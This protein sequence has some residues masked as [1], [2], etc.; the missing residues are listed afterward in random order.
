[1][2]TVIIAAICWYFVS[3]KDNPNVRKK[4]RSGL[5]TMG[6][7]IAA[8][9][10]FFPISI[11]L[12]VMAAVVGGL[13]SSFGSLIPFIII[14]SIIK[15]IANGKKNATKRE[16]STEYQEIKKN[17]KAAAEYKLTRSTG[18]RVKIVSKFNKKYNLR[19][20]D[21]QIERIM[22]ASYV[23]YYWEKEIYDM[24][25]DYNVPAEWLKSSTDW[26]RAYL[27][28]FPVMDIASD[29]N[30]QRTIV[31]NSYLQIFKAVQGK[32]Y[33]SVDEMIKDVNNMFL[34]NFDEMTFMIAHKFLKQSG[35]EFEL[36]QIGV[37]KNMSEI[38]RLAEQYDKMDNKKP[39]P[40]PL[41]R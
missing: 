25:L 26:L 12:I 37:M 39:D 17:D 6:K 29:I 10:L 18:R 2:L 14:I 41:A 35:F 19:L 20:T 27:L 21:D 38:D 11:I 32:S 3:G 33:Y 8:L 40:T 24:S 23:S 31:I 30:V 13:F 22:N 9:L 7:L 28:A 15:G 34:V 16:Q 5:G 4:F 36:P 1:M